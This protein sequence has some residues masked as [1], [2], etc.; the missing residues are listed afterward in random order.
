[1]ASYS[2]GLPSGPT[3]SVKTPIEVMFNP[4]EY[5]MATAPGV[6]GGNPASL[7]T[8][9]AG[10][11]YIDGAVKLST[12]DLQST[13][14]GIPWGQ[15]RSWGNDPRYTPVNS[16]GFGWNETY[17]PFFLQSSDRRTLVLVTSG[18]DARYFDVSGTTYTPRFFYQEQLRQDTGRLILTDTIG[19]QFIFFDFSGPPT[20]AGKLQG[21]MDPAGNATVFQYGPDFK[22]FRVQRSDT[23]GGMTTTEAYQY[24]YIN[25]GPNAGLLQNVQLVHQVSGQAQHLVRQVDY[26]YYLPGDHFGN[27]GDL[28]T[29]AIED[30]AQPPRVLDK[31]YY[32]YYTPGESGGL[33]HDLKYVFNPESFARLGVVVAD[34]FNAPDAQV[35]PFADDYYQFDS[36]GRVVARAIQGA[37]GSDGRGT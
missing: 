23:S 15:T 25:G 37:G 27:V 36:Q 3:T 28:K 4:K 29:A 11:R 13:G 10:V 1:M 22:L 5:T 12:S 26:T 35:A 8:S 7:M 2:G 14:F 6:D 21:V 17:Q 18:S 31:T 32:R 9:A 19:N 20:L 24:T 34:P 30:G 16:N 33:P